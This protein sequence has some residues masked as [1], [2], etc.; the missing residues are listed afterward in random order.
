VHTRTCNLDTLA[1]VYIDLKLYSCGMLPFL[2]EKEQEQL[3]WS[4]RKIQLVW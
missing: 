2:K 3:Y 4:W 1:Q